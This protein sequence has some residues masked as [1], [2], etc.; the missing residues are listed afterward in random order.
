MWRIDDNIPRVIN[1]M[2]S[3][4]IVADITAPPA[5]EI[6]HHQQNSTQ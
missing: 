6:G 5:A 2:I 3:E 1:K 4:F